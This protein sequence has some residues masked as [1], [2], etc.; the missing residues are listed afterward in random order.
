M[1]SSL[2]LSGSP[3]P[4]DTA[5]KALLTPA[6]PAL[7][8]KY[9]SLSEDLALELHSPGMS[10][11]QKRQPERGQTSE[12]G[13]KFETSCSTD[14]DIESDL[15][16]GK[17]ARRSSGFVEDSLKEEWGTYGTQGKVRFRS[18]ENLMCSIPLHRWIGI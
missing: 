14:R 5:L 3:P 17:R 9:H 12:P 7:L 11:G 15:L 16:P 10:R 8:E 1:A 2:W 6:P 4:G 18:L 13:S